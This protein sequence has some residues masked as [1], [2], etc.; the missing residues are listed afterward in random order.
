MREGGT[1]R[2]L[3]C[4][5]GDAS[6]V[7]GAGEMVSRSAA[8]ADPAPASAASAATTPAAAARRRGRNRLTGCADG[9]PGRAGTRPPG[10]VGTGEAGDRRTAPRQPSDHLLERMS[11]RVPAMVPPDP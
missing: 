5:C 9:P 10:G 2:T 1:P 6:G 3:T 8:D 11:T 7:P 4:V